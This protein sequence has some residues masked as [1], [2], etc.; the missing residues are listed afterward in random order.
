[1]TGMGASS[2]FRSPATLD[3]NNSVSVAP[4][5]FLFYYKKAEVESFGSMGR[6]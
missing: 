2:L 3:R 5:S 6:L 4:T 1:M